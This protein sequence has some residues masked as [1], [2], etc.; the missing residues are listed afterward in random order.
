MDEFTRAREWM[1]AEQLSKRGI[2]DARLLEAFRRV[3][4]EKFVDPEL[5]GEA[6]LDQTLPILDGQRISQ[7][8][9]VGL[10]L[11]AAGIEPE[12]RVLEVGAGSGYVA[13]LL[14]HLAYRVWSIERLPRLARFAGARIAQ[15][16]LANVTILRGDGANG[17]KPAA[18]FNVII[19]SAARHSV[20]PALLD[21]LAPGGRL[22]CPVGPGDSAQRLM[23]ITRDAA[24]GFVEEN[25]GAVSFLQLV[26]A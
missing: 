18:P 8:Y 6:Y 9:V 20:P 5:A 14:G 17:W 21:Q 11:Q 1:I 10:M 23:K 16:G 13:A 15:L 7:P 2:V 24:G 4:R 12:D 19:V 26:G 3:P 22:E 25:L